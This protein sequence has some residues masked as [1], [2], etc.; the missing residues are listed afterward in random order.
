MFGRKKLYVLG[1]VVFIGEDIRERIAHRVPGV[2]RHIFDRHGGNGVQPEGERIREILQ[3][4]GEI[5]FLARS[6]Q[7]GKERLDI[8]SG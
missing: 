5:V 1:F 4:R 8:S 6:V 3:M 2:L 7:L